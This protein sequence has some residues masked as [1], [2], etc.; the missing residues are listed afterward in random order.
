MHFITYVCEACGKKSE[1]VE[2]GAYHAAPV[3]WT[4]VAQSLHA[5]HLVCSLECAIR[6]A[7]EQ[8]TNEP[9]SLWT[10]SVSARSLEAW[11]G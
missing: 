4:T 11:K 7:K 8:K 3:G 2:N 6:F 10:F 9:D 1:P 5:P